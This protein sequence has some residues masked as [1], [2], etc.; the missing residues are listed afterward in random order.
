[1]SNPAFEGVARQIKA[2]L[3]KAGSDE[4]VKT[5]YEKK[6]KDGTTILTRMH[7]CQTPVWLMQGRAQAGV[8]WRSETIFQ[9]QSGL[10]T[11]HVDIPPEQNV[12]GVYSG[13]VVKDAVH[14]NEARTWL[15][16]LK[17]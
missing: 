16:F 3:A 1:M 9:E 5:V 12:T 10:A 15:Q 17:S 4:L 6:V 8:T 13:A 14:A 11:E 2:A 7:H